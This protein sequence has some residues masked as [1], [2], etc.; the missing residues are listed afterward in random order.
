MQGNAMETGE[1]LRALLAS[2][3]ICINLE[4]LIAASPRVS[5]LRLTRSSKIIINDLIVPWYTRDGQP[6]CHDL[7]RIDRRRYPNAHV[8]FP[9]KGDK[10]LRICDALSEK[11]DH[12]WFST[13][14]VQDHWPTTSVTLMLPAYCVGKD[15]FLLLD[16]N[17]RSIAA[18]R[19]GVEYV[20]D[21]SVIEGP[22]DPGVFS[23]LAVFS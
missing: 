17:H 23:D 12:P 10:A 2:V 11:F 22:I 8:R 7:G 16:G 18:S 21:L 1:E 13:K 14:K 9:E 15:R 3:N 5:N 4:R 20:V 19:A 6:V